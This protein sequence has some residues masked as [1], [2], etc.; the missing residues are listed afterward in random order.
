MVPCHRGQLPIRFCCPIWPE[1][2][3]VPRWRDINTSESIVH[4]VPGSILVWWY[5]RL[6][7]HKRDQETYSVMC[8]LCAEMNTREKWEEGFTLPYSPRERRDNL[9]WIQYGGMSGRWTPDLLCVGILKWFLCVS[10]P[11]YCRVR[12]EDLLR[13]GHFWYFRVYLTLISS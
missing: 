6:A 1:P 9:W 2:L 10:R 5:I 4:S 3:M 7:W 8:T 13:R 12:A 11:M